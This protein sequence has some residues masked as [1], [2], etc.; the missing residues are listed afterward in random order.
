M[1]N[2]TKKQCCAKLLPQSLFA[3]LLTAV[4]VAMG[5]TG[6]NTASAATATHKVTDTTGTITRVELTN[7][8]LDIYSQYNA[9]VEAVN[10]ALVPQSVISKKLVVDTKPKRILAKAV[11]GQTIKIRLVPESNYDKGTISFSTSLIGRYP[12]KFANN[13]FSHIKDD[14]TSDFYCVN[15]GTKYVDGRF[16]LSVEEK[17]YT[18]PFPQNADMLHICWIHWYKGQ[19][20][21]QVVRTEYYIFTSDEAFKKAYKLWTGK[22]I[23]GPIGSSSS[24]S[25]KESAKTNAN[26]QTEGKPRQTAQ[27]PKDDDGDTDWGTIGMVGGGLAAAGAIGFGAVKLFGGGGNAGADPN[28]SGAYPQHPQYPQDPNSFVYTDP[29]GVQT[30]YERDPN[31]GEWFNPSTGGIVDM[32]DLDRFNKQSM[33]DKAWLHDQ[34]NNMI[35]H[36]TDIDRA[37]QQQDQETAQKMQQTFDEIDR[38]GARDRVAIKSGTYGMSDAQRIESQ[39]KWQSLLESQQNAAHRVSNIWDAGTKTLEVTEKI[40]DIAVDGLSVITEPVGGKL[41]AD[42]YSGVKNVGKST[43]EAVAKGKSIM[44]GIGEGLA[45]GTAD[46]LQNHTGGSWKA[47]VG[48]FVGSETGKEVIVAA[49]KGEDTAQAAIKGVSNGLFKYAVSEIGDNI[50]AGVGQQNTNAMKQHYKEIN[51][52]WNKDL[53]QK[54]VNKLTSM[55]FQKYFGKETTR[56]LAQGFGQ[57]VTKEIG[58]TTY[59]GVAEGKSVTESLFDDKW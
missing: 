7:L 15:G 3:F 38:Q 9:D 52:V 29:S 23:S 26:N 8:D 13:S 22:T 40:A 56:E 37:W 45:K 59:D 28:S 49:I 34:T 1:N 44:G 12:F 36:K 55:N 16:R 53:S 42:V 31:T 18:M 17:P 11:P 41:V 43:M 5:I 19:P 35:E 57:S 50:S 47:K 2:V 14:D 33:A 32:N 21:K 48:T 24:D 46:I 25:K 20:V 39:K 6:N 58:A 30:L 54:S 51:R 4:L 27:P 10:K